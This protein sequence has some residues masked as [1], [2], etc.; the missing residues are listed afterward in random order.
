MGG[1]LSF[2]VRIDGT[3]QTKIGRAVGGSER[4]GYIRVVIP[5]GQGIRPG[6][7]HISEKVSRTAKAMLGED[8]LEEK[9]VKVDANGNSIGE[10]LDRDIEDVKDL[11]REDTSDLD[12][13]L[14]DG[15][16]STDEKSALD[17][18]R[19]SSAAHKSYNVVDESGKR[20]D[21]DEA[22]GLD[23]TDIADSRN[24]RLRK[25]KDGS[26]KSG[27]YLSPDKKL[28]AEIYQTESGKT[29]MKVS[30]PSD[31]NLI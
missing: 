29:Y 14:L 2:K 8:Y 1:V 6:T 11:F 3:V 28:R 16:L 9:G 20:V 19:K 27:K 10:V 13:A 17:A 30:Y 25:N 4:D 7:Y 18:S 5:E 24:W 12:R 26:I 15:V 23:F 22:S 21:E 31:K